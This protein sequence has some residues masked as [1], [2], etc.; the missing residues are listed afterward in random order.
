MKIKNIN[1]CGEIFD[2]KQMGLFLIY[3]G[4]R[5]LRARAI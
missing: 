2:F 4:I 1:K 5:G 3:Q